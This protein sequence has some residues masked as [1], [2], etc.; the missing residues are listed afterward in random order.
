MI[1]NQIPTRLSRGEV[2]VALQ[3]SLVNRK[4]YRGLPTERLAAT[5]AATLIGKKRHSPHTLAYTVELLDMLR[6]RLSSAKV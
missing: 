6:E 4:T 1:E 2:R 5:I 3:R